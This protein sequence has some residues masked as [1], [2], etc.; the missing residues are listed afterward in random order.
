[1]KSLEGQII[2]DQE[3]IDSNKALLDHEEIEEEYDEEAV[4][5]TEAE[6]TDLIKQIADAQERIYEC[7]ELID[8]INALLN[9]WDIND[10]IKC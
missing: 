8:K 7:K 6:E 10:I 1:M 2:S 3:I 4:P 9:L 5:E